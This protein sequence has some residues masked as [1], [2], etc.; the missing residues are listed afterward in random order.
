MA[1]TAAVSHV[2]WGK[3]EL[4]SSSCSS[5]RG[6]TSHSS[7]QQGRASRRRNVVTADVQ[8]QADESSGSLESFARLHS[9]F[10]NVQANTAGSDSPH[11][12]GGGASQRLPEDPLDVLEEDDEEVSEPE[13]PPE[14]ISLGSVKHAAGKCTPCRYAVTPG[15]CKHGAQ[16]SFC[17]IDHSNKKTR[18]KLAKRKKYKQLVDNLERIQVADPER[19]EQALREVPSHSPY[20]SEMIRA[21]LGRAPDSSSSSAPKQ[22]REPVATGAGSR[23]TGGWSARAARG[24]RGAA[25]SSEATV[26]PVRQK[27]IMSL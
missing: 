5:S 16:C 9:E 14:E 12:Q 11:E 2:V 15:G 21:R 24:F 25:S 4:E 6:G 26:A 3:L 23:Q 7:S 18:P 20:L 27:V 1:Q 10:N 8:F 17:H 22:Q 13:R 19:F